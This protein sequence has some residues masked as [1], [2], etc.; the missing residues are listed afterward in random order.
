MTFSVPIQG[1]DVLSALQDT[2]REPSTAEDTYLTLARGRLEIR[3]KSTI[4]TGF[5][6]IMDGDS[7][8]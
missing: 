1:Y 5:S 7:T 8:I 2:G 4:W 6:W 3:L